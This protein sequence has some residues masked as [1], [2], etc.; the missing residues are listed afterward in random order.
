MRL[1]PVYASQLACFVGLCIAGCSGDDD[2]AEPSTGSAQAGATV[3]GE[4]AQQLELPSGAKL[5]IPAGAVEE[6]LR[7]ELSELSKSRAAEL[8]QRFPDPSSIA[9]SLV[10][11]TP[12]GAHFEKALKLSLPVDRD[13]DLV[14]YYLE[15]EDAAEWQRLGPASVRDERASVALDHFSVV[16]FAA[17]ASELGL[18]DAGTHHEP[19]AAKA[20]TGAKDSG[21]AGSG[22]KDAGPVD[23]LP[24]DSGVDAGHAGVLVPWQLS[25][26][27]SKT[28]TVW[29]EARVLVLDNETGES[30]G[31][32]GITDSHGKVMLQVPSGL[33]FGIKVFGRL[34]QTIDT[35]QFNYTTDP[36]NPNSSGIYAAWAGDDEIFASAGVFSIHQG[37]AAVL[38]YVHWKEAGEQSWSPLKCV[39][40]GGDGLED[41]RFYDQP[42]KPLTAAERPLER[43]TGA[44][45]GYFIGNANAGKREITASLP[46]GT[47]LARTSIVVSPRSSSTDGLGV[48]IWASMY[49][50]GAPGSQRPSVPDCQ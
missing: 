14:A 13:G 6:E 25:V 11:L 38:G 4:R 49:I 3:D 18:G 22:S 40:I 44:N 26:F 20:G 45:G 1:L 16:M 41:I 43:G 50:T 30:M 10:V 35:Y 36:D 29:P 9:S 34:M 15:D 32:E 8:K 19:D 21:V 39:R 33:P 47:V 27:E 2:A 23:T 28:N 37:S 42:G 46:D 12:H 7:I 24:A 5:E 31:A 17:P 48:R